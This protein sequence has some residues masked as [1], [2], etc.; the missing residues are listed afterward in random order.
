MAVLRAIA[1]WFDRRRRLIAL[2]LAGW[3]ALVV[4][5]AGRAPDSEEWLSVPDLGNVVL[6]ILGLS[7]GL[8]IGLILFLRPQAPPGVGSRRTWSLRALVLAAA[9]ATLLAIWFGPAE[10]GFEDLSAEPEP[11]PA[12]TEVEVGGD[13]GSTGR[14][15]TSDIVT[16]LL[17][18]LVA[19]AVLMRIRRQAPPAAADIEGFD[20]ELAEEL[21]PAVTAATLHLRDEAEPRMAVLAAYAGLESALAARGQPRDPAET[22][23]EHMAR[24]LAAVPVL[25]DPAVRLSHLYELARFSDH[26]ITDDDRDR[27]ATDLRHAR[28]AL[29]TPVGN[30][31]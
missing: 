4:V 16:L 18:I 17:V 14:T 11:A 28:N 6:V 8:G 7:A 3:V 31:S 20:I 13:G 21:A 5:G 29:G 26:A 22:P 25:A 15:P 9:A 19:G 2:A 1:A 10:D 30:T 24:V 23:A 12:A 27:A